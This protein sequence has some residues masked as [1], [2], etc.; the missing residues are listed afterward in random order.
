MGARAILDRTDEL[1]QDQDL[2][3]QRRLAR[4]L[5]KVVKHATEPGKAYPP[6]A[7]SPREDVFYLLGTAG[8]T[9][10]Y[11][12]VVSGASRTT[13]LVVTLDLLMHLEG[14]GA[15]DETKIQ[16]RIRLLEET[17]PAVVDLLQDINNLRRVSTGWLYSTRFEAGSPTVERDRVVKSCSYV[18]RYRHEMGAM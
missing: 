15:V 2:T 3:A 11:R 4:P 13:E 14:V 5:V 18:A 6:R 1:L 12:D 7:G 9:G 10:T 17:W 16:E 8:D